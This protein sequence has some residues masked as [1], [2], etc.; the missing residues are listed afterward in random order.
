MDDA[1]LKQ[2]YERAASFRDRLTALSNVQSHQGINPQEVKEAD[3]FAAH[4]EAGQT[5]IQVFFFRTGNNW[6][7]RAYFPRADKSARRGRGARIPSWRSSTT[8]SRRRS[9]SCCRRDRRTAITRRGLVLARRPQDQGRGAAARREAR[10]GGACAR[11]CAR[12]FGPPPG[13]VLIASRDLRPACRAVRAGGA[14]PD[15]SRCSTIATFPAP[16]RSVP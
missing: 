3:V 15:A 11:Q 1:S 2:D 5:A 13:G 8:T 12:G 7:N 14:R 10:A 9:S 16:I 6:G 4:Q